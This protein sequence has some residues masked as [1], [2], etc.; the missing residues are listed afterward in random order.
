MTNPVL[1]FISIFLKRAIARHLI[2]IKQAAKE[3]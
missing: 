2:E 1:W 3:T